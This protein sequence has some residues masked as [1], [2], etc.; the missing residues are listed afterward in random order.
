LTVSKNA[1]ISFPH[2]I[3]LNDIFGADALPP[4]PQE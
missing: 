4:N 3:A 1:S 2:E